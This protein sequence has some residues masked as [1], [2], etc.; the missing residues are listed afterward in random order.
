VGQAC[1]LGGSLQAK[2][3]HG[4]Q[5]SPGDNTVGGSAC[6][7]VQVAAAASLTLDAAIVSCSRASGLP[8]NGFS[9]AS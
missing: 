5:R 6:G 9:L 7:H 3:Q 8:R 1:A 4:G 2:G